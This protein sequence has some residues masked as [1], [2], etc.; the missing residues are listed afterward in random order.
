M[1]NQSRLVG[2]ASSAAL[3]VLVVV[4]PP[5]EAQQVTVDVTAGVELP[6]GSLA[7]SLKAGPTGGIGIGYQFDPGFALGI[8]AEVSRLAN[9]DPFVPGGPLGPR[10]NLTH[11]QFAGE[12]RL[13]PL[14]SSGRTDLLLDAGAGVAVFRFA[15]DVF[16]ASHRS[17]DAYP[18]LRAGAA[19]LVSLSPR[20]SITAGTRTK[21]LFAESPGSPVPPFD[22]PWFIDL[23]A[24][25]RIGI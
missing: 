14:A 23:R 19:L 21:L 3:A 5:A 8:R 11:W 22:N 13:R 10:P 17:T 7:D 15:G 24:G 6:L 20:V 16:G 4:A 9:R 1:D 12:L 18:T 25:L 2:R